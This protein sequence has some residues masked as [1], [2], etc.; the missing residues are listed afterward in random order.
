VPPVRFLRFAAG[1]RCHYIVTVVVLALLA[2]AAYQETSPGP[3]ADAFWKNGWRVSLVLATV[4]AVAFVTLAWATAGEKRDLPGLALAAIHFIVVWSAIAWLFRWG[5][6][7][8]ESV[9]QRIVCRHFVSLAVL[10][11]ALTMAIGHGT[12]CGKPNIWRAAAADH[13]VSADLTGRGLV[14]RP[15]TDAMDL[16]PNGNFLSKT[17]VLTSYAG[18]VNKFH[19]QYALDPILS[20][21]ALGPQRIW[22][23]PS[24]VETPLSEKAFRLFAAAA[25]QRGRPC[26]VV[27]G[28]K[29]CLGPP[30][31]ATPESLAK[32]ADG[33]SHA[34]LV[35]PI[36]VALREYSPNRLIFDVQ[37]RANGWLLVTDRWASGWQATVNDRDADVWL[38]NFIFRAVRVRGGADRIAFVY[39]PFGHPWLL[40]LS[41]SVLGAVGVATIVGRKK[42]PQP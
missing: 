18:M 24:A 29:D 21:G 6:G 41:W 40:V 2:A 7:A 5:C 32:V 8:G 31:T 35:E 33:L 39:R 25:K 12:V 19:R 26:L 28:R 30:P 38:G 17:P 1:F 14:R 4:A 23:A 42:G 3:G 16:P 11:A 9:R 13:V 10:D 22:F 15:S 36:A 20:A 37:A 27:A 34:P